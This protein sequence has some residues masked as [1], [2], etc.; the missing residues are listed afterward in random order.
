MARTKKEGA[1]K[2]RWARIP[3]TA[4]A[5]VSNRGRVRETLPGEGLVEH[6]FTYKTGYPAVCVK[7][8]SGASKAWPVHRAVLFAFVGAPAKGLVARHL[9]GDKRDNRIENLAWG[10][11]QENAQDRSRHRREAA[12]RPSR[13]PR[14]SVGL[15]AGIYRALGKYAKGVPLPETIRSIVKA[16]LLRAGFL[17]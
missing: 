11:S 9:N 10:T 5:E 8:E 4:T 3:G 2:E 12:A 13:D 6:G 14:V 17:A 16:E 1:D 7:D 15:P